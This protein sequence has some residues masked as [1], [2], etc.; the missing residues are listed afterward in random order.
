V[1]VASSM[2]FA[3]TN[4]KAAYSSGV[5]EIIMTAYTEEEAGLLAVGM[6]EIDAFWWPVSG[7]V[8]DGFFASYPEYKGT[9]GTVPTTSGY[10]SLILNPAHGDQYAGVYNEGEWKYLIKA[11]DGNVYFNPFAIREVRFAINLLINRKFIIDTYLAGYGSPIFITGVLS[12]EYTYSYILPVAYSLGIDEDGDFEKGKQMIEDAFEAAAQ[13]LALYG[14][15]LKKVENTSSPIGY[16]WYF[17]GKPVTVIFLIRTEDERHEEGLYVANLLEMCGIKVCRDER[18][19]IA[20]VP[21]VYGVDPKQ[22]RDLGPE[23]GERNLAWHIYTEGWVSMSDWKWAEWAVA[24]MYAP[25]YGWMPGMLITG[26]WQYNAT[27]CGEYAAKID[28]LT[29]D[30]TTGRVSSPEEYWD[31]LLDAM[32]YG[33]LESVRV[34]VCDQKEFF[35]YNKERVSEMIYGLTSG[36]WT[37]WPLLTAKTPN[38]VFRIAEHSYQDTMYKWSAW[39]PIDGFYDVYSNVPFRVIRDYPDWTDPL[40]GVF[41]VRTTWN[42]ETRFQ[43]TDQGLEG[44]IEVPSDAVI[45]DHEQHKWVPVSEY[46]E[47]IPKTIAKVE[48]T[49][50]LGKWHDGRDMTLADVIAYIALVYEWS[51]EDDND[52]YFVDVW[53]PNQATLETI[54]AYKFIPEENK[55]IVWGDYYHIDQ[56][57]IADYF[58]WW[59]DYPWQVYEAMYNMVKEGWISPEGKPYHWSNIEGYTQI[60]TL[61]PGHASDIA[62]ALRE[63]ANQSYIPP[64]FNGIEDILGITSAEIINSYTYIADWIDSVGYAVDSNGPFMV[65]EYNPSPEALYLKMKAFNTPISVDYYYENLKVVLIKVTEFDAPE[66]AYAGKDITIGIY[67]DWV[68]EM[69]GHIS[70]PAPQGTYIEANVISPLG[71]V[72]YKTVAEFVTDGYFEVTI[73]SYVTSSFAEGTYQIVFMAAPYE[74]G[75]PTVSRLFLPVV[76]PAPTPTPPTTTTLTAKLNPTVIDSCE[77]SYFTITTG[78]LPKGLSGYE[79]SVYIADPTVAKISEVTLPTWVALYDIVEQTDSKVRVRVADINEKIKPGNSNVE[80][81]TLKIVGVSQG[82]TEIPIVVNK[83]DDDDGNPIGISAIYSNNLIVDPTKLEI[84]SESTNLT[85]GGTAKVTIYAD[86]LPKGLSGYSLRIRLSSNA[87]RIVNVEFPSWVSLY[88]VSTLPAY[89]VNISAA[90][91]NNKV[92][93]GATNVPLATIYIEGLD[94]GEFKIELLEYSLDNDDGNPIPTQTGDSFSTIFVTLLPPLPGCS[95]SP[96][97]LDNDGLYEDVNGN[98]RLDF[99]DVVVLFKNMDWVIENGYEKCFD[100]NKNGRLDFKD[101]VVLFNMT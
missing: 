92:L 44:K 16:W 67:A 83:M 59:P 76:A 75:Y 66:V 46:Y 39:N 71:E 37:R 41:P 63:L 91:L 19:R 74:G 82:T 9:I 10:W 35:T 14:Y 61:N 12:S 62:K 33:M 3:T 65:V 52:Y 99:N 84:T 77:A 93:P 43:V 56:S 78:R 11:N 72:V 100:F 49:Y 21:I 29:Q 94:Q 58:V 54:K 48:Y 34:A 53:Q 97:D 88:D 32:K 1:L 70:M 64:Y 30:L 40:G 68:Q 28:E 60:D 23:Y 45:Y 89:E 7:T 80:L 4:V 20:L 98:G 42:V 73:P 6:G 101:I 95:T 47:E 55:I 57:V 13:E 17:E 50:K 5:D 36:L 22:Y 18:E 31:K 87:V 51:Y 8:L 15:T 2:A 25:W 86:H 24:Q 90:D 69:P 85:I 27:T 81:L 26:Y 38:G 96:K 79:I